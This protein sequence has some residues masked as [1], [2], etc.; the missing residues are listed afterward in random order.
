GSFG[1]RVV[2]AQ[3][4]APVAGA[5]VLILDGQDRPVN[6]AQTDPDGSFLAKLPAGP[7]KFRVLADDRLTTAAQPFT[8]APGQKLGV[9][10]EMKPPATLAVTVL[11]ELGRHAPAK[12]TLVGTFESANATR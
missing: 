3:T 8:L 9:H 5:N 1:G 6:H 2:D 12:I 7:Y 10:V 11:D 4:S